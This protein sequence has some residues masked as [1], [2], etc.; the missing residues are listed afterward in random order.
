M[1]AAMMLAICG[2]GIVEKRMSS[3][4]PEPKEFRVHFLQTRFFRKRVSR[5]TFKV[6]QAV[7]Q[8]GNPESVTLGRSVRLFASG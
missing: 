1:P 6:R 3:I 5:P 4:R 7:R 8:Q 2:S